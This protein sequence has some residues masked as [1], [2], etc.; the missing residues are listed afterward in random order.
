MRVHECIQTS[1]DLLWQ[2][3]D[4]SALVSE[5]DSSEIDETNYIPE[6]ASLSKTPCENKE[7]F[8]ISEQMII[9]AC[10]HRP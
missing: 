1:E 9:S 7:F 2:C 3:Q 6:E 10:M 5:S 4:V 8:D